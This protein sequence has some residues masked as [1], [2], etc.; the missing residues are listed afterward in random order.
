MRF[1]SGKSARMGWVKCGES[2][3]RSANARR[4]RRPAPAVGIHISVSPRFLPDSPLNKKSAT[5]VA[6]E[7]E[8]FKYIFSII[9]VNSCQIKIFWEVK[10][11]S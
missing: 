7:A 5:W 10:F 3:P 2:T 6:N 11:Y 4:I 9:I 1:P 8:P